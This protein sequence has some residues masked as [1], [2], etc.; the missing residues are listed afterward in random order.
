MECAESTVAKLPCE[1]G[2]GLDNVVSGGVL[3][4]ELDFSP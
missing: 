2:V 1:V 4:H 3:L